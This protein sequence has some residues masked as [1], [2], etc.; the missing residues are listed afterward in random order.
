MSSLKDQI[1]ARTKGFERV[2]D[3]TTATQTSY[4][5]FEVS[6]KDLDLGNVPD[7]WQKEIIARMTKNLQSGTSTI[8]D[9]LNQ[10]MMSP[11]WAWT[12]DV[13]NIVDTGALKNS[14]TLRMNGFGL[15]VSYSKPYA[16]IVH[17][18]GI[19]KGGQMYPARPWAES[20][21]LGGGPVSQ[22]NWANILEGK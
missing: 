7:M 17:Y 9:M 20:V 13:R 12:T 21:L 6:M 22:V 14:L 5:N 1:E 19:L 18:G 4:L 10:A 2:W 15:V 3:T 16:A 11:V 8:K